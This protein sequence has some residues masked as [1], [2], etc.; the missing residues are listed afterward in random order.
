[1][2]SDDCFSVCVEGLSKRYEIYS[3]PVDRLKQ[4]ILPRLRRWA[5]RPDRKYFTEFWVLHDVSFNVKRGETVGIVGRNGSGKSTLLQ[6]VCGTLTPTLGRVTV[7]GRVAA[8]LELGSG[9]NPEFTG[10]E[11]VYM[12][13][14]ILG[15][16]KEEVNARYAAIL[17]FADI[18]DFIDQPVKN[19]SSGMTMR[20][21]FSVMAHV[22][23]DVLIVDEALAVGDAFFTQKCMRFLREFKRRGTLLFVSHD[24]SA[25]TGLCDRAIWIERGRLQQIGAANDV[26]NAYLEAFMTERQGGGARKH[27]RID[28]KN[29]HRRRFDPRKQ[30]IDRSNLRNDIEFLPFD[31]NQPTFGELKARVVDIAFLDESG[32]AVPWI[33]GGEMVQLEITII[34]DAAIDDLIIGFFIKDKLGLLLFGDNT[35]L[36]TLVEGF[37]ASEGDAFRAKFLFEMPRLQQGDYFVTIGVASGTQENHVVQAWLH[38]ALMF[39]SR[40]PSVPAGILGIPMYAISVERV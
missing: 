35:Y 32:E 18:G 21:A 22:D 7:Q 10:R 3:Q 17:A 16:T 40:G 2:S 6:L 24:S 33:T 5:H 38:E 28:G 34:A 1:M 9:F 36:T 8:L 30:L 39:K 15:L 37:R 14:S 23:A 26:T 4:M 11:N 27:A 20:L 19:Y 13:A 31:P 25:V 29:V 12:N